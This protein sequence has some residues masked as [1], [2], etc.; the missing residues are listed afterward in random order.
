M[1]SLRFRSLPATLTGRE[2]LSEAGKMVHVLSGQEYNVYV[3]LVNP[4]RIGKDGDRAEVLR[5]Y[6]EA[7]RD[8]I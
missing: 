7:M 1:V 8:A 4:Y 6:E 3:G 5:K 2:P